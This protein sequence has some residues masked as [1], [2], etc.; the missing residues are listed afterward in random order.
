MKSL[1]CHVLML[2]LLF[3]GL[4]GAGEFLNESIPHG[5]N[6]ASHIDEFGHSMEAHED[7]TFNVELEDEHCKHCCHGHTASINGLF[8]VVTFHFEARDNSLCRAPQ[9]YNLA[10]APPTPPPNA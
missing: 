8:A 3:A 6:I 5:D 9:I 2:S 7:D 10:Q 4:E 1:L